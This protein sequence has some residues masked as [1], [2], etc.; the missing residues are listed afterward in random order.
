MRTGKTPG[1]NMLVGI[2][3]ANPMIYEGAGKEYLV[4]MADGRHFM[5]TRQSDRLFAHALPGGSG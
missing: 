5:R 4:I 2:G 1:S 3:Q